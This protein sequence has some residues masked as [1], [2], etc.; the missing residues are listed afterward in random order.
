MSFIFSTQT[1]TSVCDVFCKGARYHFICHT[2]SVERNDSMDTDTL[3]VEK[4]A[5][6]VYIRNIL[7]EKS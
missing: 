7:L 4:L 1:N 2:G 5:I 6:I 3:M